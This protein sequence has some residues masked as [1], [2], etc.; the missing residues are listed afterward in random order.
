MVLEE[1]KNSEEARMF[2]FGGYKHSVCSH[3]LYIYNFAIDEWKLADKKGPWPCARAGHAS[4]VWKNYMYIVGGI[5]ADSTKLNDIWRLEVDSLKW[6]RVKPEKTN[7]YPPSRSGHGAV[8]SNDHL[9]IFGG[10]HGMT[11]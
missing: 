1:T 5:D 4:V 11:H 3:T 7:K 6:E 8:V 2:V 9:F 10:I